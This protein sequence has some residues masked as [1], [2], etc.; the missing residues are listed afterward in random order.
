MDSDFEHA[1]A[2]CC[3]AQ[4]RPGAAFF[5]RSTSDNGRLLKNPPTSLAQPANAGLTLPPPLIALQD[6][7]MGDERPIERELAA[8]ERIPCHRVTAL[9]LLA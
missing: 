1:M 7:P 3:A 6:L 9:R 2:I 5:D 4:D 8:E